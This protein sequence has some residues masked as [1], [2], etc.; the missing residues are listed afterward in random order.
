M[1]H[2]WQVISNAIS[3]PGTLFA[4]G[5][6]FVLI[7]V[8]YFTAKNQDA[9]R[10]LRLLYVGTFFAI[11]PM[12]ALII[13]AGIEGKVID[14][15]PPWIELP[16][17]FLMLLLPTT[18]AYLII[19]HKAMDVRVVIRQGLQYALARRGVIVLQGALTAALAIVIA[20]Y[21]SHHHLTQPQIFGVIALAVFLSVRLRK[22]M[23]RLA[24]WIDRRF[25][26]EA[27]NT[28]LLLAELSENVRSIVETRPLLETVASR[29]AQALHVPQIAVLLPARG[30]FNPP[31]RWATTVQ[32]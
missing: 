19:V 15:F 31:M 17:L 22:L 6:F 3:G 30:P 21:I 26:R 10:R 18:L 2:L 16:A 9:R 27:Y 25:F 5:S 23:A 32:I 24:L 20:T 12:L 11:V 13:A 14:Q 8:K 4:I 1:P 28:E 29:I 7:A